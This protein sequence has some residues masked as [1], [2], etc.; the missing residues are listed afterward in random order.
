MHELHKEGA[1]LSVQQVLEEHKGALRDHVERYSA[2][3]LAEQVL[4]EAMQAFGRE[5]QDNVLAE[6]RRLFGQLTHGDYI[7]ILPA[8]NE[9]FW[10]VD[11]HSREKTPEQLS[12]GTREQ[13]YLA[14]RLAY[15]KDYCRAREPLPFVMDDVLVNFDPQRA[16]DTISALHDLARDVQI[17]FL[18]CHAATLAM[19]QE[20]SPGCAAIELGAGEALRV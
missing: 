10:V 6:A 7:D 13:L 3:L 16:G 18:T 1:A 9:A 17:I 12:R 8:A 5:H 14:F 15:V 20:H 11:R 4:D 2:L 19:F